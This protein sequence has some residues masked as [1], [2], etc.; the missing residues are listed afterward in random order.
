MSAEDWTI[1]GIVTAGVGA[2]VGGVVK[3]FGSRAERAKADLDTADLAL[4]IAD[5][6]DEQT[7]SHKRALGTCE[8]QLRAMRDAQAEDRQQQAEDR[9]RIARLEREHAQCPERIERLERQVRHLSMQS[10]PPYGVHPDDVH[11]AVA[12]QEETGP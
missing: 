7:A 12:A 11:R 5:R 4:R 1:V 3:L 10:T 8:E 6:A 9:R 2:V